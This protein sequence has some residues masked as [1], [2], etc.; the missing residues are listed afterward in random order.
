MCILLGESKW[1]AANLSWNSL[2]ISYKRIFDGSDM[3]EDPS[4]FALSFVAVASGSA[5]SCTAGLRQTFQ[6]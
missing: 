5:A 3:D 4:V 6:S 1:L 2:S